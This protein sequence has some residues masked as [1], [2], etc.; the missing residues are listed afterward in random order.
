VK[1]LVLIF[2]LAIVVLG[3]S[4]ALWGGWLERE[5]RARPDLCGLLLGWRFS[6]F[7]VGIYLHQLWIM[8]LGCV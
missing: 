5:G 7:G 3:L 6:D 2:T 1:D 4:A 8:W